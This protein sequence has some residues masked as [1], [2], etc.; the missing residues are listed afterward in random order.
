[1]TFPVLRLI[2]T[3]AFLALVAAPPAGA[4]EPFDE[5]EV[6]AIEKIV[7][8]Y[9]VKNPEVVVSALREIERRE[10]ANQAQRQRLALSAYNDAL[11]NDPD[12][13]V[14]G[15]PDGDVTVVEF[16]D[17]SCTYCKR[18]LPVLRTLLR[19]DPNIRLV[20]KEFPILGPASLY[21]ARAAIA[22]LEQGDKYG[23]FHEAL[24]ATRAVLSE[25]RVMRI[26]REIGLDVE[27]LKKDMRAPKVDKIIRRNKRIA[28]V[29]QI[30]GTPS[31]VIGD[32]VVPGY[33]GLDQL[34]ALVAE[35]R[36]GC[37]TC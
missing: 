20:Y 26:A 25:A 6:K 30:T 5:A 16:F 4:G 27:R 13:F 15:N 3:L 37:M 24:M 35:A 23:E 1:M 34:V 9:L 19:D 36:N 18:A 7:R 14:G 32:A 21:A 2:V 17:Y 22:A 28:K 10:K 33:V 8:D 11:R 31:F 29:L 12:S